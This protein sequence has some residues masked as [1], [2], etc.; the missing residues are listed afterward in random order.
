[1]NKRIVLSTLLAAD[2][3]ATADRIWQIQFEVK[4]PL[5]ALADKELKRP[6]CGLLRNPKEACIIRDAINV[7]GGSDAQ[8]LIDMVGD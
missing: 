7:L 6:S 2:N 4:T 8:P 5:G 1:L 3:V